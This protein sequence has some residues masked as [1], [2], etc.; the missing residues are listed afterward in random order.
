VLPNPLRRAAMLAGALSL[1][2][3]AGPIGSA[4]AA[5]EESQ[6]TSPAGPTYA[7]SD[8]SVSS[9]PP[10]FKVEGTTNI[11]GTLAIRCYFGVKAGENVLLGETVPSGGAFSLVNV[12]AKSLHFGPCVLRA[13]PAADKAAHP[14]GD[15]SVEAA[16]PYHGPR[17]VGSGFFLYPNSKA[18]VDY[19]FEAS[20]LEGFFDI[21]S[22]GDCGLAYS[23][24]Y[25]PETLAVSKGLFDCNAFLAQQSFPASGAATRSELQIDGANA[26][27]PSAVRS[28]E[29]ELK[30]KTPLPGAPQVT[31]TKSFNKGL[32]EVTEVD[33]IVK[34][35]PATA[36]PPTTTGCTSLVPTGV[37]LERTW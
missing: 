28:L 8:E 15:A 32:V 31:V 14:P 6:I 3:L 18:P 4:S 29:E 26:Y 34:C 23:S 27:S 5:G 7:L 11:T 22:V 30:V 36:F 19:E 13:V 25:A 20:T 33:P 2:A 1:L 21:D 16:D 9:P 37:Q 17:V 35:S 24:L 10:A 12:E